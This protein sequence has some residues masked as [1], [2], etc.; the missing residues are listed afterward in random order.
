MHPRRWLTA[1]RTRPR[2]PSTG[3]HNQRFPAS[4]RD[5]FEAQ[6]P[7]IRQ[8]R[9]HHHGDLHFV[10]WNATLGMIPLLVSFVLAATRIK[11]TKCAEEPV[12][13]ADF[14]SWP[15]TRRATRFV[16]EKTKPVA[17]YV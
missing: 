7:R 4:H 11:I 1:L 5:L 3:R 2:R 10:A 17:K 14:Q 12:F 15:S 8:E 9:V 13:Y 6:T 16:A